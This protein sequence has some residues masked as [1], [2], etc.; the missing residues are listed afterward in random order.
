MQQIAAQQ[1]MVTTLSMT[2]SGATV[3]ARWKK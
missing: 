3:R 2:L 1:S